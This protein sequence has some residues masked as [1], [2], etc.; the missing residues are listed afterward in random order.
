MKR[1]SGKG[2]GGVTARGAV[3]LYASLKGSL[4][5]LALRVSSHAGDDP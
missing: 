1:R 3:G 5:N 2:E 4:P